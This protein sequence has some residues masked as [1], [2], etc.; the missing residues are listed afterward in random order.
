MMEKLA[1]LVDHDHLDGGRIDDRRR[2]LE[3]NES[4]RST[5]QPPIPA[6]AILSRRHRGGEGHTP[7]KMTR[8][9]LRQSSIAI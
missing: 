7:A 9:A 2:R 4:P 1:S 5:R 8:K 6:L 3:Q